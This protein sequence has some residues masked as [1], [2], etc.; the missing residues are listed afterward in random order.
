MKTYN[1][2]ILGNRIQIQEI[3][4]SLKQYVYSQNSSQYNF[5]AILPST[6]AQSNR[7]ISEVLSSYDLIIALDSF[8]EEVNTSTLDLIR[9][10]NYEQPDLKNKIRLF[11]EQTN[12]NAYHLLDKKKFEDY[13]EIVNNLNEV[14]Y[15]L[16]DHMNENFNIAT[17]QLL[18]QL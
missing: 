1:I 2:G 12:Y 18:E 9:R 13:S 6:Y 14:N 5:I 7:K 11:I 3:Q 10:A 4:D 8:V 15:C 16:H 17:M